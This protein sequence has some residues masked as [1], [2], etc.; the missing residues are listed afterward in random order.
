[1]ILSVQV[2][3]KLPLTLKVFSKV[4]RKLGVQAGLRSKSRSDGE[5][6][7]GNDRSQDVGV[8]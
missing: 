4:V 1:M 6:E 8:R 7:G 5:P 2:T 3:K